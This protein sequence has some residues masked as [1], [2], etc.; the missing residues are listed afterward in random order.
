MAHKAKRADY[1]GNNLAILL[2]VKHREAFSDVILQ[3]HLRRAWKVMDGT[4]KDHWRSASP[5]STVSRPFF[6]HAYVI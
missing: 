1:N 5:I 6:N 2:G 3:P 4:S